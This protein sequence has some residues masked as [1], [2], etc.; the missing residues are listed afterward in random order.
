MWKREF[1][2]SNDL[3]FTF[4]F[5]HWNGRMENFDPKNCTRKHLCSN[6]PKNVEHAGKFLHSTA[7]HHV[8]SMQFL[9]QKVKTRRVG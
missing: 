1:F 7:E 4:V 6:N 9:L 8:P 2:V 5:E 3:V